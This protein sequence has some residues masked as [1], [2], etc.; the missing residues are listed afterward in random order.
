MPL[1][2]WSALNVAYTTKFLE[3]FHQRPATAVRMHQ[4]RFALGLHSGPCWD[5][6]LTISRLCPCIVI[7]IYGHLTSKA[8]Y[9]VLFYNANTVV[10][11]VLC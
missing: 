7:S 5:W 6:E 10:H 9:G 2:L 3:S 8:Y 4:I 1:Q 11:Q